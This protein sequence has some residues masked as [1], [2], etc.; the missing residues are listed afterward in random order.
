METTIFSNGKGRNGSNGSDTGSALIAG[1]AGFGLG[2]LAAVGRRAVVQAPTALAGNWDEGLKAEHKM[3]MKLFDLIEKTGDS[4]TGK[5]AALLLQ[6]QHALGKHA[7]EEEDV[8]YCAMRAAGDSE[9]ADDLVH[10]HGYVK[11]ALY[12]L[13]M[14]DKAD[15]Q[16]LDKVRSFRAD[17]EAHVRREE[18]ELFPELKSRLS[19]EENK[20]LTGRMN[21]EGF[22][23]A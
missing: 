16:W 12:D 7:V 14:M 4:E 18:D 11:Q 23:V 17:V 19:T 10:D 22:K 2:L 8:I 20:A 6:L 21:R 9:A 15:P 13:E 3:A 1:A 5:R